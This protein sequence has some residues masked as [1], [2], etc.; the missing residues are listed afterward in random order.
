MAYDGITI[1]ALT[2]EIKKDVVGGRIDKIYQPESDE[3]ILGIRSFGNAY[4]LMLT[5]NP[6]SPKFHLT[7]KNKS[8]PLNPPLFCM[9]L[10]KHLQSGKILDIVQPDFDRI[11][12]IKIESLNEMGDYCV[13]TLILEV[14]GRHS[15]IILVDSSNKI[16]DCAKHITFDTSSVREVLPGRQ[17]VLPPN[18]DKISPLLLNEENFAA[19]LQ[20]FSNQKVQNA[21]Y[22]SYNGISPLVAGEICYIS[23]VDSSDNVE[24][25]TEENK[26][27]LY[28]SFKNIVTKIENQ[29]FHPHIIFNDGGKAM[30]FSV[31]TMQQF[32]SNEKKDFDS[33]SKLIESYYQAKDFTY[34]INQKT[35]DLKHLIN[36]NI[37]RCVRKHDMQVKTLKDIEDRDSLRLCGELLTANIYAVKKGMTSIRLQNFYSE[38]GEE[39]EIN[40]DGN[41]TPS[42]NA[43]KYFKKYNKAKRTF[44]ALQEQIKSNDEELEYLEGVL[45]SVENCLDE[46]DVKEIR[47]EL[48]DQGYIKRLKNEKGQKGQKKSRPMHYISSDGFDI[49]VGKNNLQNDELTLKTAKAGDIWMHTKNIPGSHVIVVAQRDREI[50]QTALNEGA[51]LAAYYSKGRT[52][53]L[54]P[55]DYTQKRNVKKPNGAKPGF[56]IYTTNKTAYITPN[57]EAVEKM[58]K[59]D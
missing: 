23:G 5:A 47:R 29:E 58:Q 17:Y 30:D 31:L 15:N 54:V 56:V 25:L 44:V 45:N 18:K 13:N 39:V 51:M 43:Q 16:L 37:D 35:Q 1:S 59:V 33:T 32:R 9:V 19:A 22:K 49:Y 53:A 40:L 36:Q 27:A 55:V 34:R 41:L 20:R 6:S 24:Q 11:I 28:Y 4:R 46:Q 48:R 26:N 52:S 38:N 10:R 14:M 21:I 57:E 2:A 8:N 50:S 3:V 42:E 7:E 12:N